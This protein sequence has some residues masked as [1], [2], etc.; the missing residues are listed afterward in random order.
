[1]AAAARTVATGTRR[2]L[3]EAGN[4]ETLVGDAAY[5]LVRHAV[6]VE[7][8]DGAGKTPVAARSQSCRTRRRSDRARA[9]GRADLIANV[10]DLRID[11]CSP[12]CF[13]RQT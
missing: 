9:R 7:P 4:R 2:L 5:R 6:R 13:I 11:E 1:M 3:R 12:M 10:T 8:V